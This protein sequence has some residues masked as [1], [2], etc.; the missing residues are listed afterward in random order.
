MAAGSV[1]LILERG[2][3]PVTQ[4][5]VPHWRLHHRPGTS[6]SSGPWQVG[7]GLL[8][9]FVATSNEHTADAIV[10]ERLG[11]RELAGAELRLAVD[12]VNP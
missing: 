12:T 8:Q 9:I 2:V 4:R 11:R 5:G 7:E 3:R 10:H 1:E 6:A